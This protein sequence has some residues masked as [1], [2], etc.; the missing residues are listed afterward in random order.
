M[1]KK[2]KKIFNN[3]ARW[4]RYLYCSH[5]SL[6]VFLLFEH[7]SYQQSIKINFCKGDHVWSPISALLRSPQNFRKAGNAE[8]TTEKKSSLP[9]EAKTTEEAPD[10]HDSTCSWMESNDNVDNVEAMEMSALIM[11]SLFVVGRRIPTPSLAGEICAGSSR[12][13]TYR[14]LD[15][16]S[17]RG[18]S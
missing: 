14:S 4:T 1:A 13:P 15:R 9:P 7:L 18:Q 5:L 16:Q 2:S 6:K 12:S 17:C 3:I 11:S 8:P 10:S